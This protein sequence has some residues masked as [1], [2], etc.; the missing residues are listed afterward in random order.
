MVQNY[1]VIALRQLRKNKLFSIINVLG[2]STGIACC[3]LINLYI[4]DEFNFEKGFSQREKIFRINTTF[5]TDGV[6]EQGP[7]ASPAIAPGLA[8][9]IP[10]IET[11]A[12]V[13]KP[14][15]TEVNIVHYG[16]NSFFEKNAY[17]VDSTFLDVF[18]FDLKEGNPST[19]LDA[20]STV[21]ISEILSNKIFHDRSPI[22]ELL[23]INSGTQSDTFRVTGVVSK[24]KF[25]S[26]VDADLYMCMNS[27]GWGRWLLGQ[28]T[29][30]NNNIVGSYLKLRN[31]EEYKTVESKF[32]KILDMHAGEELKNSGRSKELTLQPLQKIR[33]YSNL[34]ASSM[35]D[36]DGKGITYIYIVATIGIL[37]LVLACINFMNLT[38]AKSAQRAG[39]VGIRKSMG[40]YR[41]NL[42]RQFLGESFVI[43]AFALVLSFM[44]VVLA[45]P[46]FN[47][48]MQK[49]LEFNQHNLPFILAAAV[50]IAIVTGLLAGSYPAFFLSAM[51]PT[52]VLKGKTLSG[53]GSQWLRKGLVVFQFVITITL[54][55]SIVIIQK[56]IDFIQTKSLGFD[57]EQVI[58]VPMRTAQATQQYPAMKDAI[59][60]LNGVNAVSATSSV[61]STPLSRD[62]MVYK[63][64]TTSDKTVTHDIIGVDEG[65]FKAMDIALVAGRDFVVGQDNVPTDT[66]ATTKIIVNEASLKAFDISLSDAVGSTIYFEPGSERYELTVVGVVKDFHQFSLHRQIR[67]MMLILSGNRNFFPY[68]AVNVDLKSHEHVLAEIKKLWDDR[69][70]NAPFESIFVNEN[71]KNM[72]AA[73]KRTSTVLTISTVIALLISCFGL[74]GLSLY[75]AERKTKEIG[76][77]KVVGATAQSIVGMLSKEYIKLVVVSFVLSVPIGYYFMNKW[78]EGFA[79]KIT[80]GIVVFVISGLISFLIAWLTISF[81]SFRAANRNP[82]ETLR[83]Q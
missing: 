57:S 61:P 83:N 74:Y 72:Y 82:V 30:A 70:D 37:I 36:S 63:Q 28:T 43:V 6:A 32:A 76:I 75:V 45:L 15:N 77:R 59:E 52:Q 60:Q 19:A 80:P 14:L 47:S 51:K 3:V 4:Q 33:L 67:P 20:P 69:I 34:R 42:I 44:I 10:D 81:E 46:T 71:V 35:T 11:Y 24:S 1:I 73:E 55:S 54:I 62:W 41:N 25:P 65:Y 49:Q 39:E 8:E 23:I 53:D 9:A 79:Y 66:A 12:R 38:T 22:D 27:R 5:I 13:M 48:I 2:L 16:E 18:D 21:L 64:G 50:A 31:P 26:H 7:H 40:A 68:M 17:L 56:Q 78:L 29:W 58:M